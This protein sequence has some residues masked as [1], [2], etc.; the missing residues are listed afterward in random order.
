MTACDTNILF[1][2]LE[3]SH[4]NH[5]TARAWLESKVSDGTFALCEL[6][7]V[8]VYTLLR[9][10]TVCAKPLTAEA[11]VLKIENLRQ[12]PAWLLL[13]Y[14]GPGHMS[15][16][17]QAARTSASARR[18]YDIRLAQTLR[19]Y[20]VTHFATANEKHFQDFGFTHVWSPLA[21]LNHGNLSSSAT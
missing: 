11:A 2:A 7:L 19:H 4:P 10:P 20:G 16:I 9:N 13:D 15:P 6:V 8:E 12:N 3:A 1:P 18:I 5:A 17:W 14:P 21:E